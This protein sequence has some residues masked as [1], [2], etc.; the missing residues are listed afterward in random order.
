[1]AVD[2]RDRSE[3]CRGSSEEG[4]TETIREELTLWSKAGFL[5][6]QEKLC[7]AEGTSRLSRI[8]SLT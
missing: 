1:M 7:F 6:T 3:I 8:I 5:L 2:C 4:Q